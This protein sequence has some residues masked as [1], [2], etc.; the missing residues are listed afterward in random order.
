MKEINP[1]CQPPHQGSAGASGAPAA[2]P[3][4]AP[5]QV[6]GAGGGDA[7]E[8]VSRRPGWPRPEA[9][10]APYRCSA[11]PPRLVSPPFPSLG[12]HWRE[13]LG[14]C[15]G[16]RGAGTEG[17]GRSHLVQGDTPDMR[18]PPCTSRERGGAGEA[19]RPGETMVSGPRLR[20]LLPKLRPRTCPPPSAACRPPP[21]PPCPPG[22]CSGSRL[23]PHPHP[24]E[25]SSHAVHPFPPSDAAPG[26]TPGHEASSNR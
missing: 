9:G 20:P 14:G 1:L 11:G 18:C 23:P 25:A 8:G 15:S 6:K 21:L 17:A 19:T 7:R 12:A 13:P 3:N 22:P 16:I 10:P 26:V 5:E 2:P 4:P 24:S